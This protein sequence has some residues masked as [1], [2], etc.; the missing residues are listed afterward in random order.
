MVEADRMKTTQEQLFIAIVQLVALACLSCFVGAGSVQFPQ[1]C[2]ERSLTYEMRGEVRLL[3]FWIGRDDVGGGR[4]LSNCGSLSGTGENWY[5]TEVLFGSNPERVPG[6]INRWGYGRER[7]YWR[8]ETEGLLRTQFSGVM[9]QSKEESVSQ[10]MENEQTQESEKSYLFEAIRST[11]LPD[12]AYSQIHIFASEENFDYR[13]PEQL[14][15]EF[16]EFVNSSPPH[17][18][19]QLENKSKLYGSPFGFLSGASSLIEQ[20]VNASLSTSDDWL[21]LRPSLVYVYSAKP[22][23][24]QV[25]KIKGPRSYSLSPNATITGY[26]EEVPNVA[27]IQFRIQ[28][29]TQKHRHH[30]KLWI[31]LQGPLRATPLRIVYQ[32]RWWLRVKLELTSIRELNPVNPGH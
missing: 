22:Y 20:I 7:S 28:N 15:S 3:F 4:I 30:F 1:S 18:E 19:K 16:Q 2:G 26:A 8:A 23:L 21:K 25:R 10:T 13:N 5:E 12:K 32:P 11:V 29:L 31:P 14:I 9:R 17:E 24:L 27:E 6:G